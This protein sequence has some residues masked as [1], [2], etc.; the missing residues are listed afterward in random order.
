MQE[1]SLNEGRKISVAYARVSTREQAINSHALEQQ[2]ARL[3][4]AGADLVIFDMQSGKKDDRA[5]LMRVLAMIEKGEVKEVIITRVDRLGRRVTIIRKCVDIFQKYDIHLRVLDQDIAL[6][7]A[8][9]KLMLNL[10]ASFAEAEVDQLSERVKHGNQHRRNQKL[11]C[12]CVPFGY[13]VRNDHYALDHTPFLCLLTDRPDHYLN[14]YSQEVEPLPGLSPA[15]LA[16]DCINIFLVARGEGKAIRHIKDKYG[17]QHSDS[18]KNGNDKIFH[19]SS[20][21]LKR[22][23]INPVLQ[24]H[25]AYHKRQTLPDGRRKS[26]PPDQWQIVRDTHPNDRLLAEEQVAEI[27]Q[28]IDFNASRVGSHL[29]TR[30]WESETAYHEFSYLRGL[31]FCDECGVKAVTKTRRSK[32]GQTTYRYYACRH[33]R[34]GCNNL[35]GI[36]K[37]QLEDALVKYLFQQSQ[38]NEMD[39]DALVELP[40]STEKLK[41]LEADLAT[42]EKMQSSSLGLEQCKTDLRQQI[43]DEKNPFSRRAL[44]RKTAQEIIQAG[45]NLA[46]WNLLSPDQKVDIIPRV[47]QRITV[48]NSQ[49]KSIVLK[50]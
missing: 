29:L 19:W 47:V 9:G 10:L 7:N 37:Q 30:A 5:G 23:L 18:K 1:S 49:V 46:V 32:D 35:K 44:E 24:G 45:N 2:M 12:S 16:L 13:T 20:G 38:V 39:T 48:A 3:D 42:L 25:T 11:A 43:H 50:A 27:Q 6:G 21:S 34:K 14:F 17:I 41:Q 31:V 8:G 40:H 26:L 33:A 15:Q 28:I 22:W 4:A 36:P